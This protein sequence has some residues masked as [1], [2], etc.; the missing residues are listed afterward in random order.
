MRPGLKGDARIN[1]HRVLQRI[2][3][4]NKY[5]QVAS[6]TE[7]FILSRINI[8]ARIC[9][10]S[11]STRRAIADTKR[12]T[13]GT[14]VL[15]RELNSFFRRRRSSE[16]SGKSPAEK[17]H[18][19]RRLLLLLLSSPSDFFPA[20]PPRIQHGIFILPVL[21]L[22]H[23]GVSVSQSDYPLTPRKI[24]LKFDMNRSFRAILPALPL[25][26]ARR[27]YSERIESPFVSHVYIAEDRAKSFPVK[28]QTRAS[29]RAVTVSPW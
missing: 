26:P 10:T 17:G 11:V 25:N 27:I 2:I 23:G 28:T 3:A 14:E 13:G 16:T 8:D 24:G 7:H 22:E 5:H 21:T 6:A 4:R 18:G 29:A 9:Y 20:I 19:T 1:V 15:K 12:G